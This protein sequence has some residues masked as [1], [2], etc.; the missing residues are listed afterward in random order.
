MGGKGKKEVSYSR[1]GNKRG[2]TGK[3]SGD[4]GGKKGQGQQGSASP[5][6]FTHAKRAFRDKKGQN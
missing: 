6:G 5:S 1:F 4:T 2:G 3:F